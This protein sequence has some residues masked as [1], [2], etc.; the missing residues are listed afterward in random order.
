MPRCGRT[1]Q[2]LKDVAESQR[3]EKISFILPFI[4]L[5]I[6]II[7]LIHAF[8]IQEIYVI[9]LTMFLL[10]I[11]IA[12]LLFVL[13][14]IHE[15]QQLNSIERELT[16]RLDDFILERGTTNVSTVVEE[17][18]SKHDNYCRKRN[19]VYHIACQIMETHE[20][21]LWEKNLENRLNRFIKENPSLPLQEIVIQFIDT[22]PEYRQEPQTIYQIAAPIISDKNQNVKTEGTVC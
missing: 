14:E 6:E 21:E 2:Y 15:H 17:F 8:S 9:F 5:T 11:S 7:L 3:F 16:I 10:V 4:I 22:F 1:R 19:M 12:E 20:K 18:L 13:Q